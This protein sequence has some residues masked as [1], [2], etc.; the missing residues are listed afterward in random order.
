MSGHRLPRHIARQGPIRPAELPKRRA[1]A[2][3]H[4]QRLKRWKHKA[5]EES[6]EGHEVEEGNE[7]EEGNEDAQSEDDSYD[8]YDGEEEYRH[9][10]EYWRERPRYWDRPTEIPTKQVI[11]HKDE[12]SLTSEQIFL[13]SSQ[14]AYRN[15]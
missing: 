9:Y 10:N 6:K 11:I 3:Y 5:P 13:G 14:M 4:S 7:H 15:C 2:G 8:G 1:P 12:R